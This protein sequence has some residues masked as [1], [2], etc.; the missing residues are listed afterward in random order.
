MIVNIFENKISKL[1]FLK[2]SAFFIVFPA[3]IDFFVS[4]NP[5]IQSMAYLSYLIPPA[6]ILINKK[7][8]FSLNFFFGCFF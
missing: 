4:K 6:L 8:S 5:Y 2:L 7:I 1:N 3:Y